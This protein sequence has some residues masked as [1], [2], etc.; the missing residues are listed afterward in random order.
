MVIFGSRALKNLVWT[1]WLK[2][3]GS[4]KDPFFYLGAICIGLF[5][6]LSLINPVSSFKGNDNLLVAYHN[7]QSEDSFITPGTKVKESPDLSLIQQNSLVSVSPPITVTPQVLGALVGAS[8]YEWTQNEIT[9]YA[10]ES[11]D[12]LSS[13][14]KQF[15]VSLNT[16]LWAN[17]LNS[18]SLLQL[19]QTLVILPVSGVVHHVKG[20]DTLSTI[21]QIYKS[22]TEEIIIFN[23][24]TAEGDVY[25]GDILIVP[26]GVMPP[27]ATYVSQLVP[28]A[29]SYF[30]CPI[31]APCRV[32]Q[33]LHFY[34]AIDFSHGKCGEPIY[35]AA[36]GQVVK[37]KLTNSIS[38]WAFGGAGNTIAIQHPNSVVTSYGHIQTSFIGVGDYVSQGQIVALVGGAWGM[39][40]SGN[41]TG[42]HV[43]FGVSGAKNPFI[44]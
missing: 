10:V 28:M 26:N 39:P 8:D 34:N 44:K 40:G 22:T 42:C 20:G 33:G 43:H 31:S 13:I 41:S 3:K 38:R 4:A 30:I 17:N 27:P 18:S 15:N 7:S 36:A 29:A 16:L 19:G 25:I 32:T 12:T 35:A 14:A 2:I 11:G 9:E 37:V 24:L 1:H 5:L 21:A 23:N 6:I